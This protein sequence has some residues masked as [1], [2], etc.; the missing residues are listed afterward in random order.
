MNLKDR[1]ARLIGK[2]SA[3]NTESVDQTEIIAFI[4]AL[5]S[6]AEDFTT[7][8]EVA[9]TS[10]DEYADTIRLGKEVL[11]PDLTYRSASDSIFQRDTDATPMLTY[12]LMNS[13][14]RRAIDQY[15]ESELFGS[16]TDSVLKQG[17]K[18]RYGSELLPDTQ[19]PKNAAGG[20]LFAEVLCEVTE[21]QLTGIDDSDNITLRVIGE[22]GQV[23]TADSPTKVL[24]H[25]LYQTTDAQFFVDGLVH[26]LEHRAQQSYLQNLRDRQEMFGEN[27]RE[28]KDLEALFSRWE[29]YSGDLYF[30]H[31]VDQYR[32]QF[33]DS[34]NPT[35]DMLQEE[36]F[37]SDA[38]IETFVD[39]LMRRGSRKD[40]T[41]S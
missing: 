25:Q 31:F 11:S 20:Y 3:A 35:V 32:Q 15:R 24:G 37:R 18:K 16:K 38:P 29:R 10:P 12:D 36:W 7:P 30:H 28:Y 34:D 6:K 21:D 23:T 40:D 39:G 22:Q 14:T 26:D 13:A 8:S 4:D 33:L 19:D 41:R 2:K 17:Y 5:Q 9:T 27:Y 1:I